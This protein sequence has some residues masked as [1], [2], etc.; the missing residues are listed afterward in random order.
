M[1][2][3]VK[4]RHGDNAK[5]IPRSLKF[6]LLLTIFSILFILPIISAVQIEISDAYSQDETLIAKITGNFIDAL[7]PNNIFF[8]REH[9]RVPTQFTVSKIASDYYLYALLLGKTPG[10]YSLQ[11]Q[12]VRYKVGTETKDD[13][14]IK[15][16]TITEDMADFYIVPG[17]VKTQEDFSL[18]LTNLKDGNLEVEV[19]FENSSTPGGFFESLFGSGSDNSAQTVAL[20]SGQTKK[21]YF[22]FDNSLNESA[23]R[24]ISLESENTSYSVPVYMEFNGTKET[25]ETGKLTFSPLLINVSLATNSNTTRI[26]YLDNKENASVENISIYVSEA[27][28]PYVNLSLT[29]I[30]EIDEN[31]SIKIELLISSGVD[32]GNIEGQITAVY[33]NLSDSD[34]LFANMA[35]FLGFIKDYVPTYDDN[36]TVINTKTCAELS[37]FK[38]GSNETCLGQVV[39][40]FDG[41]CCLI[42]C[43]PKEEGSSTGKYIGWGLVILVVLFLA[44][45]FMKKYKKV[46][47]PVDL[48][49]V[50]GG[51][52]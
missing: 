42:Q 31:S 20:S 41:S 44:W 3:S 37:G 1:D 34:E 35:I 47:N 25:K 38:C 36:T 32:E 52:K 33:K 29:N 43:V 50:A 11:I 18:Q 19:T 49:K 2:I 22:E 48:L 9:V 6:I 4:K 7:S 15:N 30:S 12:D 23:F 39:S 24:A 16:F 45:F 14:V 27:L 26:I 28:E 21:V 5:K 8:Y 13:D 10:N 46:S 51:K 17:F 40:A